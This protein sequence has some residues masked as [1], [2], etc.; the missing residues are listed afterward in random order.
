M[1]EL[2]THE[3]VLNL[4]AAHRIL[5]KEY[6]TTKRLSYDCPLCKVQ[7]PGRDSDC[8]GCS[9]FISRDVFPHHFH[10]S[11]GGAG[12]LHNIKS[13]VDPRLYPFKVRLHKAFIAAWNRYLKDGDFDANYQARERIIL[14]FSR[15]NMVMGEFTLC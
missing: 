7:L 5:I 2:F 1:K 4:I 14:H 12:N 3:H 10:C 13:V 9:Y 8:S 6:K 11:C 15:F